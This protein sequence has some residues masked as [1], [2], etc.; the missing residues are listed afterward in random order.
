MYVIIL[1]P[2]WHFVLLIIVFFVRYSFLLSNENNV[3]NVPTFG[4]C[5]RK[6]LFRQTFLRYLSKWDELKKMKKLEFHP[7]R[8]K[9]VRISSTFS[10]L[11]PTDFT[12]TQTLLR[13]KP[14][15]DFFTSTKTVL[16]PV[17]L[18]Q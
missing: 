9:R 2:P 17:L 8:V 6:S 1:I 4:C 18:D 13:P 10:V 11:R 15:F 3:G 14:Y 5:G 7:H 12:S 16:R